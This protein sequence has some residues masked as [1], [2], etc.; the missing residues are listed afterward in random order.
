MRAETYSVLTKMPGAL[1]P[2][3]ANTVVQGLAG[4]LIISSTT[5]ED[6]LG[7]IELCV[8]RSL[9]SGSVFDAIHW[10]QAVRDGAEVFLTFNPKDSA[11][12][13]A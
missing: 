12:L 8:A 10:V 2:S 11:R 1:S 3:S 9:R 5:T 4:T 7:A 13:A 6:Y